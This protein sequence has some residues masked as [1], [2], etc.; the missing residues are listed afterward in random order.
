MKK[1]FISTVLFLAMVTLAM[2]G[3]GKAVALKG[4]VVDN[5]GE[6]IIGATVFIEETKTTVYTDFD[7]E[8]LIKNPSKEGNTI[9]VKMISYNDKKSVVSV[10]NNNSEIISIKLFYK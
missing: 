1:V 10:N 7:G 3:N 4:K 8:F 2:A 6:P 5:M 9:T